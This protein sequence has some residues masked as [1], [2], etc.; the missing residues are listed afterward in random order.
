MPLGLGC[1]SAERGRFYHS[2]VFTA[3]HSELKRRRVGVS[4]GS[5]LS[6][7]LPPVPCAEPP[8][9]AP[10]LRLQVSSPAWKVLEAQPES[11]PKPRAGAVVQAVHWKSSHLCGTEVVLERNSPRSPPF[12]CSPFPKVC[13]FLLE[14]SHPCA[15]VC[16]W[17]T[18]PV[19]KHREMR[20]LRSPGPKI[21]GLGK[22]H[23]FH[24]TVV[25]PGVHSSRRAAWRR[26]SAGQ[27][28]CYH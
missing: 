28:H 14:P 25:V 8:T 11:R 3:H 21:C 5:A 6:T 12:L 7:R 23:K 18:K 19:H 27:L 22:G 10:L 15:G 20:G 26:H 16:Q 17:I 13:P 9:A 2:G 1:T 4:Q 24:D